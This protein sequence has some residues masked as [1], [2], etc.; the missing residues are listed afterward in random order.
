MRKD[1]G[2]PDHHSRLMTPWS[3][4]QV[5]FIPEKNL[6]VP[7]AYLLQ[8]MLGSKLRH[9]KAKLDLGVSSRNRENSPLGQAI[10]L[11]GGF[12]TNSLSTC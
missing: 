7:A 12:A 10:V 1:V 3:T 9:T 5:G 6:I 8:E 11:R 4:L 2:I